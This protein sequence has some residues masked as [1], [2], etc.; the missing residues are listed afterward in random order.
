MSFRS[1]SGKPLYRIGIVG[2]SW[3]TS[4]PARPGTHKVLGSAPPHSHLSSLAAIPSV[5]V[6]AGCDIS[7]DACDRFLQTWATTWPDLN[8]YD[9]YRAMVDAED[10][11]IVCVATPDHLHGDVVRYCAAHGVKGIFCEKPI[12]V[13]LDDVDSMI[14]S[15]EEFGTFVNI[16][17]T[18]R[19][20]PA[21]VAAREAIRSGVIGSLSQIS[22]HFGGDRAMLWRNHSHFLDLVSYF[23]ESDPVWV[24]GELE[25][26][27]SE[28]GTTYRGDGGRSPQLEPGVNAY[29][30]YRNGVRGF[31]SGMKSGVAQVSVQLIG[32][33]GRIDASDKYATLI[34]N[35]DR[36][37]TRTP[38]IPE[39]TVQSIQAAFMDLISAMETGE[40]PQCPPREARKTVA[41]IEGIL[42]SH[43]AGNTRIELTD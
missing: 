37:L 28:Y 10:L 41:I 5:E 27:L 36:G 3:I 30:A 14:S 15:L 35:S 23:A 31:L 2:L 18:R 8:A 9:D 22:L 21:Y 43:Q 11:D 6:V 19:W 42:K 1:E 17:N 29:I 24:V 12:S 25:S 20:V 40:E 7:S 26:N 13:S 16:N 39:S 38:I 32:S 34:N 4:E 33:D